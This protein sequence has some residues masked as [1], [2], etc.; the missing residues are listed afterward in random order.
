[1]PI[2]RKYNFNNETAGLEEVN[3]PPRKAQIGYVY[4]L[5]AMPGCY[6]IGASTNPERRLKTIARGKSIDLKIIH[7]IYSDDYFYAESIL[8]TRYSAFQ[9]CVEWF[10]LNEQQ[11]DEI[12]NISEIVWGLSD[13]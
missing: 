7:A 12:M 10:I 3:H 5:E 4:I 11:L 9:L 8:Q 6:K 1:M 2:I 13:E